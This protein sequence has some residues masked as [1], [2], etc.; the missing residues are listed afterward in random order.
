M[1]DLTEGLTRRFAAEAVEGMADLQAAHYH[2][3]KMNNISDEKALVLSTSTSR[4]F[5]EAV[6]VISANAETIVEAFTKIQEWSSNH[7]G[8]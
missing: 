4:A 3:L 7:H 5:F 2:R 6:A 1:T 8:D